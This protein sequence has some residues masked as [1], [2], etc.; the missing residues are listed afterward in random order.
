MSRVTGDVVQAFGIVICGGDSSI[1]TNAELA[2]VAWHPR[3]TLRM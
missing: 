3:K 2:E 1:V